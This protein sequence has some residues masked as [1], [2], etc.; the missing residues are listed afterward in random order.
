MARWWPRRRASTPVLPGL[1]LDGDSDVREQTCDRC[2]RPYLLVTSYL[3]VNGSAHCVT[4]TALHDHDGPEAWVD[5]VFGT[6]V[7]GAVD[8]VTFGCRVGPVD[9]SR[10]PAATAVDAA[11]PYGQSEFWGRK[12]SRADAL[13]HP[14]IREFWEVVDHVLLH[15]PAVEHHV[16]HR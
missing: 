12:L 15:E 16:Y 9:G 11:A 1:E 3:L 8:H 6:F 4:K 13:A 7:E 2:G 14:R 5:V 10:D